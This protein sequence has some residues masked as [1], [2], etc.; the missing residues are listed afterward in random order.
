MA[1]SET[2]GQIFEPKR[3]NRVLIVAS[4]V[5]LYAL[6]FVPEEWGG[7]MPLASR[8]LAAAV[9]VGVLA[10]YIHDGEPE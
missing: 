9:L 2:P 6:S 4:L 8:V 5:G 3:K 10:N 7:V 1:S